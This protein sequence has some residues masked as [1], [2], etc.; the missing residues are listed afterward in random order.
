VTEL[1]NASKEPF[2][3]ITEAVGQFSIILL[4]KNG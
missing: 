3:I 2:I 1:H 4:K